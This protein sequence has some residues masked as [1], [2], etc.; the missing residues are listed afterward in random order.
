VAK[1]SDPAVLAAV[2]AHFEATWVR[3]NIVRA[4]LNAGAFGCL[5]WALVVHGRLAAAS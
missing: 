5:L 1:I 3:W 2:R 4:V